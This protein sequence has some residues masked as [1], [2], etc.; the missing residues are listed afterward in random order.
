MSAAGRPS[1]PLHVWLYL[2]LGAITGPVF[3]LTPMLGYMG[4]FLASLVH[5]MGHAGFA[6]ACGMPAFPAIALDGHAA[7]MHG[8][9]SPALVILIALALSAV[10]WT[11]LHGWAKANGREKML[12]AD[13]EQGNKPAVLEQ[14]EAAGI[15]HVRLNDIMGHGFT[16]WRQLMPKLMATKTQASPHNWGSALKAVYTAHLIAALGNAPTIEG[17]SSNTEEV[18]FGE[19]IIR[20]ARLQVSSAPGFGLKLKN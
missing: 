5:E 12:L 9:Q 3:G 6:W 2:G 19:N 14:L 1:P 18:D 7:A 16:P 11:K 15:L 10:A 4:W 20:D 13:G 8:E 17:V